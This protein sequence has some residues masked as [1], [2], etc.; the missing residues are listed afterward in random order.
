MSR[1]WQPPPGT[2]SVSS[3]VSDEWLV[4]GCCCWVVAVAGWTDFGGAGARIRHW[5][6]SVQHRNRTNWPFLWSRRPS[7]TVR[8]S[9]TG[10][11]AQSAAPG[12]IWWVGGAAEAVPVVGGC[13]EVG[14]M[15]P[16]GTR[17]SP[18]GESV[19]GKWP[20]ISARFSSGRQTIK[21]PK[22]IVSQKGYTER[23]S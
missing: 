9:A 19:S 2:A 14:A 15:Q 4:A 21:N 6:W 13:G 18:P 23:K 7:A 22:F 17:P 3:R 16:R 10:S 8:A 5:N 12:C 11:A 1:T 20:D